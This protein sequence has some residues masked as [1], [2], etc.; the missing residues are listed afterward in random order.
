MIKCMCTSDIKGYKN[1]Q[2]TTKMQID[3]A[4]EV[5][6]GIFPFEAGAIVI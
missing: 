1:I 3:H 4:F 5:H 6:V 2:N